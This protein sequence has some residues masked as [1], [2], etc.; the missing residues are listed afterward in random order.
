V[1]RVVISP[2]ADRELE[3]LWLTISSD[4]ERAANRIVRAIGGK[5]ALLAE[6]P[7][8]GARRQN[9][10]PTIRML[11]EYP[12]LILYETHPNTD[13]GPIDE[14]EIVGVVDGRRDLTNWF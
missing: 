1:A 3:D 13:Q 7:R 5:I 10:K 11:V 8:L 14:V 6:Y 12:Y 4:D 9:I 2:R